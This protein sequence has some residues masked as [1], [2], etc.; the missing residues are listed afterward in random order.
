MHQKLT[1]ILRVEDVNRTVKFYLDVLSFTFLVGVPEDSQESVADPATNRPLCF[2]IVQHGNVQIMFQSYAAAANGSSSP[3]LTPIGD[4]VTLYIE[5]HD[6]RS[7]YKT[8]K[9]N[10]TMVFELQ[11]QFYGKEEFSIKDCNGYILTFAGDLAPKP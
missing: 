10:V 3:A 11:P 6:I 4:M 8:L 5:T 1:P 9:G 2:A 7:L